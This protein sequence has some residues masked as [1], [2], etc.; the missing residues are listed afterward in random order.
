MSLKYLLECDTCDKRSKAYMTMHEL[1]QH[2]RRWTHEVN[3]GRNGG[4]LETHLCDN[5]TDWGH[6]MDR[7]LNE[8]MARRG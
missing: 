3:V 1:K 6:A 4:M 5:C 7:A 2:T 8:R